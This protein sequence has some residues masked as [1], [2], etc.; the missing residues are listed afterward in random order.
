MPLEKQSLIN[1][2]TSSSN[3]REDV[4]LWESLR[5]GNDLAFSSLYKKYVQSLFNYGMHIH[6]NRDL[7][8]DCL[9]ELFAQIWDK[10]ETLRPVEKVGFYLFRSFKNLLFRKI[11]VSS[12]KT[13]LNPESL[14]LL[15]HEPSTEN[16]WISSERVEER[17]LRLKHAVSLLTPRQREIVL[18]RF[19]QG[20]EA[21]EIAEIMNLSLAGVHNLLSLTVKS[22][23]DKIKWSEL[24]VLF[25]LSEW[26]RF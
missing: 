9:Q 2:A 6:P 18:L 24:V 10:R 8:I 12:K 13:F 25:F 21:K 22:L 14:D 16:V 7:V 23:R 5:K 20:L 4:L 19:F 15:A 3:L 26:I 11:E 17:V 1:D